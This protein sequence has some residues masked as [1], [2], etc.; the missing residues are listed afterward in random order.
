MRTSAVFGSSCLGLLLLFAPARTAEL[1]YSLKEAKTDLPNAL[2]PKVRELFEAKSIQILDAQQKPFC[3]I[4]FRKVVP[5]K[6]TPEQVKNG[7]TYQEI[8]QG[9]II[10]AIQF[11]QPFKDYR[12]QNVKEGVYTLRLANQPQDG[13]HMG[14]APHAEFCLLVSAERDKDPAI[15]EPK[16]LF[17][18]SAKSLEGGHPGVMLLF[19]NNKPEAEPK[20]VD[21][22]MGHIVVTLPLKVMAKDKA[23]TLGIGLTIAGHSTAG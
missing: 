14:T 3:E 9:T 10:A 4:W 11:P 7:L 18:H 22:G 6:A 20:L 8:E 16:S 23:T 17:D 1:K 21:K 19:P 13:D 2:A 5:S 15:M 12:N